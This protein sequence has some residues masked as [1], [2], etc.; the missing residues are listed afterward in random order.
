MFIKN[1][2]IKNFRLFKDD[3]VFEI[4]DIN[5]PDNEN[6]GSGL[7]VLVGENG[8][9][10][11]A[12]LE[13]ISMPLLTYKS[14]SIT[15]NDFND[16]SNKITINAIA[17]KEFSVS[18]T[19]PN[20][21]FQAKGFQFVAGVRSRGNKAYLSSMVVSDQRFIKSD[22][23]SKPS[24]DSPDLRVNVNNPFKGQRFNEND[25]LFL[26]KNRIFQTRT[27]TYNPTR[28]DRLMEDFSYQYIK[29]QSSL[30]DLNSK[31]SE[32]SD[33]V[34]NSF[35]ESAIDKFEEISGTKLTLNF[36][37]NWQ[38]FLKAF[39]AQKKDNHQQIP[40]GMLG[41]GYEMVF[42]LLYSFYLSQQSEKQL[43]CLIDEPELHLHP[44]LQ[45]GFVKLLLEFSKKSQIILTTHSPLL[46]KHLHC[47]EN[48]KTN[49]LVKR[50]GSVELSEVEEKLLPYVSSSE[51]NYLAFN[52]TTEEYH[53]ELY[54]EL[55]YLHGEDKKLKPFDLDYFQGE[56]NES[57]DYPWITTPN[58]VSIHTYIR[59]QIHHS[60]DNGKPDQE[61]LKQS[62]ATLRNYLKN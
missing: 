41:S 19:M 2:T 9:G 14:D 53:N 4:K 39:F 12:L 62:I 47:N 33:D 46:I 34:E 52:L 42:S 17:E 61:Q 45:E 37:E 38:P 50:N 57:A 22:T 55:K 20:G 3:P 15:L 48:V 13:A 28:F 60:R 31:V 49:I 7:T 29:K 35:L 23:S 54:E 10:K 32:I 56:K 25:I 24:D 27:G 44:S 58:Q 30:E 26:D 40:L 16:T 21:S 43:I 6:D 18:G 51:I 1:V 5:V 8:C 11:T 36:I 59:N